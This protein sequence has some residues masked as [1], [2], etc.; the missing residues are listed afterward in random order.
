MDT[1]FTSNMSLNAVVKSVSLDT[2][3]PERIL[4]HKYSLRSLLIVILEFK[5]CS[6]IIVILTFQYTSLP[7]TTL[8]FLLIFCTSHLFHFSLTH[9]PKARITIKSEWSRAYRLIHFIVGSSSFNFHQKKFQGLS[10][11]YS[12]GLWLVLIT[13]FCTKLTTLYHISPF[14]GKKC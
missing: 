2:H 9:V 12:T 3:A 6:Q 13:C 5:F 1:E 11:D 14:G 4:H 7:N 8:S 10:I